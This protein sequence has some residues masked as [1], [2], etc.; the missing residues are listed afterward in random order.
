[1]VVGFFSALTPGD[2][3]STPAR[4]GFF[5]D[6]LA[7]FSSGKRWL[8]QTCLAGFVSGMRWLPQH[9]SWPA[10]RLTFIIRFFSFSLLSVYKSI[11][12]VVCSGLELLV[13]VYSGGVLD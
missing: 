13:P 5:S 2:R 7:G 6:D 9:R 3:A 11:A 4:G 1:M 8:L 12:V 10:F